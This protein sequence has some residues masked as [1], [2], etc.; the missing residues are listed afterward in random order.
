MTNE[1]YIDAARD[2]YHKD[3]EIEI[4]DGAIVSRGE[5][6][7]A[8][9]LAWVWVDDPILAEALEDGTEPS[10]T[11]SEDDPDATEPEF[12]LLKAD[13]A[14]ALE[15]LRASVQIDNVAGVD[16][17]GSCVVLGNVS[18]ETLKKLGFK[19]PTTTAI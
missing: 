3:G 10:Y 4:D 17:E 11:G 5:D 18:V 7:G 2:E 16:N 13:E 15:Q 19:I 6:H 8:Y 12:K 14:E 9:V 1:Q